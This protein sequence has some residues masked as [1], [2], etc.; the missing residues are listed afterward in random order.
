MK[1]PK[2]ITKDRKILMLLSASTFTLL[3][4]TGSF[5]LLIDQNIINIP[6]GTGI[7]EIPKG[8]F[9]Y[10][11]GQSI[12]F[13]FDLDEGRVDEFNEI[14]FDH[15]V[16]QRKFDD[17]W[18]FEIWEL[19]PPDPSDTQYGDYLY[20]SMYN[21][22]SVSIS[23]DFGIITKNTYQFTVQYIGELPES[24][25]IDY[26]IVVNIQQYKSDGSV[27]GNPFQHTWKKYTVIFY[28]FD[29]PL[30]TLDTWGYYDTTVKVTVDN[31]GF[32]MKSLTILI[33]DVPQDTIEIDLNT[34]KTIFKNLDYDDDE[35]LYV[36][37]DYVFT[38]I[39]DTYEVIQS[40][41]SF[42]NSHPLGAESS[43]ATDGDGGWGDYAED[44]DDDDIHSL[45]FFD[46]TLLFSCI[47]I[48]RKLKQKKKV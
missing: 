40:I 5:L 47:F 15:I 37:A 31:Q 2:N 24:F 9:S 7:T 35:V 13:E 22:N 46:V 25:S 3:L 42:I 33:N 26:E 29:S 41:G 20:H 30:L 17:N 14:T 21:P 34:Y 19:N 32:G 16:A 44:N 6:S 23:G 39:T 11:A 12:P 28:K 45:S 10:R 4:F 27:Y 43:E 38:S 1:I 48:L 36:S 8:V 18:G